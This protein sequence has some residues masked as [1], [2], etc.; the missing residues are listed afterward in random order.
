MN[1]TAFKPGD[2]A[3]LI[4]GGPDMAVESVNPSGVVCVWSEGKRVRC[5]T[6]SPAILTKRKVLS[7]PPVIVLRA[8]RP[9]GSVASERYLDPKVGLVSTVPG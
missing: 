4:T 6:I 3:V 9:D 5:K 8:I 7:E 1:D 2:I